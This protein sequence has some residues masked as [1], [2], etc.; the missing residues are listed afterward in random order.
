MPRPRW[1][2]REQIASAALTVIDRDGLAVMS[3]RTV[4]SELGVGTMSLYRYLSDRAELEGWVVELVLGEVDLDVGPGKDWAD[5][6]TLLAERAREAIAEHPA[7]VPLM[8]SRRQSA[9]SSVRWGEA[10]LAAL[11]RAGFEGKQRLLAFRTLLAFVL[12]AIQVEHFGALAGKGTA[13][14]TRLDAGEF[15]VLTETARLARHIT[16]EDEFLSGLGVVLAGLRAEL[17]TRKSR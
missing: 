1:L 7:I 9:P 17:A 12:G 5:E 4:A 15:P 8:L 6:I 14:L 16:P 2:T 13:A 10:V 3:M 11:A